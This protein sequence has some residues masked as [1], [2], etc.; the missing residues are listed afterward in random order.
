LLLFFAWQ[1]PN[2][3]RFVP[4]FQAY[5]ALFYIAHLN[6]CSFE[7]GITDQYL[8]YPSLGR[9]A[10]SDIGGIAQDRDIRCAVV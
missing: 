4:A 1:D 9:K 10:G 7:C 5:G 2:Q 8:T 3:K 6:I